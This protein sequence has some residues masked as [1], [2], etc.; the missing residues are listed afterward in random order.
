MTFALTGPEFSGG[1]AIEPR[2]APDLDRTLWFAPP[3]LTS[4]PGSAINRFPDRETFV[5]RFQKGGRKY[6]ASPMP[7]DCLSKLT[8]DDAAALYEF[9]KSLPPAGQPAP[10]DPRIKRSD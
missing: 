7:W 3:N 1:A 9:F 6:L 2:A 4:L 8:T 5:A 10:E